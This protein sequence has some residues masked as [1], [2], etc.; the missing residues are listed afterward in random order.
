MLLS[1]HHLPIVGNGQVLPT[2]LWLELASLLRLCC[3]TEWTSSNVL[4]LH[5]FCVA[6]VFPC[7][8]LLWYRTKACIIYRLLFTHRVNELP[9]AATLS[10][11]VV[12]V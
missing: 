5:F 11:E 12:A 4:A 9:T 10:Q 7:I 2:R 8:S 6:G 3:Y 1:Y